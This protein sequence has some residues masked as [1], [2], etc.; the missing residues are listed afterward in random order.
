MAGR[1][2]SVQSVAGERLPARVFG[3]IDAL[4]NVSTLWVVGKESVTG[5]A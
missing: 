1:G 5:N 3:N 2:R 4:A